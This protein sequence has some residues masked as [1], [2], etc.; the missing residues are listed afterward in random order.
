[1]WWRLCV[2]WE[3]QSIFHSLP[4]VVCSEK[5]LQHRRIQQGYG[6]ISQGWWATINILLQ[7]QTIWWP[8]RNTWIALPRSYPRCP[9]RIKEQ[10]LPV[11]KATWNKEMFDVILLFLSILRR[12]DP[13]LPEGIKIC[14]CPGPLCKMVLYCIESTHPPIFLKSFLDYL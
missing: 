9:N 13:V 11:K 14:G 5:W 4:L 10:L 3:L 7:P 6:A 1:M 2:I 8:T 12:L